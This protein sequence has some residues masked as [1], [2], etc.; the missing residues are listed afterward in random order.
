R[1]VTRQH[2]Q[3]NGFADDLPYK[4]PILWP[5]QTVMKVLSARTRRSSGSPT[6]RR[7][8]AGGISINTLSSHKPALRL[9]GSLTPLTWCLPGSLIIGSF[10][11]G[12][13]APESPSQDGR[14]ESP[15]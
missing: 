15:E 9:T 11:Q 14:G 12:T 13:K 6:R 8:W 1:H 7:K 3:K 10:V 5:R 2:R 4:M